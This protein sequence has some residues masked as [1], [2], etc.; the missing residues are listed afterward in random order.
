MTSMPACTWPGL[1]NP[2]VPTTGA[3]TL[4]T[5]ASK[6][7]VGLG[8]TC[9]LQTLALD[10]GEPTIQG[11]PKT[12]PSVTVRVADT[13]GL[14]IGKDFDHLV[15]M[16]DLVV[17]AVGSMLTGQESQTVTGLFTGD[18]RTYLDPSWTIPGQYC[19]RQD[20]PLPASVLGVIPEVTV[21]NT[22]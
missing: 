9:D 17:G 5:P 4:G 14:K 16:K 21:G 13:L 1:Q 22:K 11:K 15:V 6:V 7:T 8:Y 18:A 2:C 10:T 12:I 19:I 20:Q 3:F